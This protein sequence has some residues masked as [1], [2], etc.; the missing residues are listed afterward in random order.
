AAT[1]LPTR[2][3]AVTGYV[4][5]RLLWH[6][7]LMIATDR[8]AYGRYFAAQRYEPPE[9]ALLIGARI[10]PGVGQPA[11][12]YYSLGS[13][14][15]R[16]SYPLKW[17]PASTV[18]LAASVG[19][20]MT[21]HKLGLSGAARVHF[22][23]PGGTY[24]GPVEA[25]YR[26]ALLHSNNDCYNRLMMIAGF[27]AINGTLL[28]TRWGL[29]YMTLQSRYGRIH[30]GSSLRRS[31]DIVY[32]EGKRRGTIASR[33]GNA[34]FPQCASV[35]NCVAFFEL[36]EVLRRVVLHHELPTR[37]RF[38]I[39]TR[40]VDKINAIL[41]KA[42]N[43]L[44]PGPRHALGHQALIYNSVGRIPG[45]D[46]LEN[47]YI[48]D[49]VDKRRYLLALL[50]RF[51]DRYDPKFL[52]EKKLARF[53][54]HALRFLI[55]GKGGLPLQHDAGRVVVQLTRRGVLGLRV[56]AAVPGATSLEAW[57]GRE[58]IAVRAV[59]EA[60]FE[61]DMPAPRPGRTTMVTLRARRAGGALHAYRSFGVAKVLTSGS[62]PRE[63]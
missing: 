18:K 10:V 29:P 5:R 27:D 24:T 3:R 62:A 31:P 43:R 33:Y 44:K 28:D 36:Q 57:V 23:E 56:Q 63:M 58:A 4:I 30:P 61:L 41:L 55:A 7:R 46:L 19:A 35:A 12:V 53:G 11:F 16:Y 54:E 2:D 8:R 9:D 22:T 49:S 45:R 40:D 34:R 6:E 21:L 48:V 50:V 37:E 60:R 39:A 59:G 1:P 25:L 26:E 14:G 52:T 15:F 51:E 13:S 17:F 42:R 20:L 47:A 38:P 32:I